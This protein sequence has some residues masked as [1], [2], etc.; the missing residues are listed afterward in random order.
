MGQSS[1]LPFI[2]HCTDARIVSL[3]D[4]LK[5]RTLLT[6]E[7]IDHIDEEVVKE[8]ENPHLVPVKVLDAFL[9]Y[10]G[11]WFIWTLLT[12]SLLSIGFVL[13]FFRTQSQKEYEK[14]IYNDTNASVS[15]AINNM[16]LLVKQFPH[17][18]N[19]LGENEID[20]LRFENKQVDS[21]HGNKPILA[22]SRD[23]FFTRIKSRPVGVAI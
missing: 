22:P 4:D 21:K 8:K 16:E 14:A 23:E 9:L 15:K 20:G 11:R 1:D 17:T 13:R 2:K 10:P 7:K 12:M 19:I 6:K 3:R 18:P 5:Q